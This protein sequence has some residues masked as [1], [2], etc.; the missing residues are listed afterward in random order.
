MARVSE[1][2]F[3]FF[4]ALGAS[5]VRVAPAIIVVLVVALFARQPW[6]FIL[7]GT[8]P[9]LFLPATA[10]LVWWRLGMK[11]GTFQDDPTQQVYDIVVSLIL[12][13]LVGY[14][15]YAIKRRQSSRA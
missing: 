10:L 2:E 1:F 11:T 12:G 14:G 8:L 9:T 15:V 7:A 5:V 13:A 4:Q 3:Y 6:P